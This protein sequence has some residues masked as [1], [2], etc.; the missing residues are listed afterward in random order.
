VTVDPVLPNHES[1]ETHAHLKRNSGFLR[2][3]EDAPVPFR[4][5][6]QFVEDGADLLRLADEMRS[7]R[8]AAAGVG[9]IAV[10]EWPPAIRA[11][12]D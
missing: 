3:N 6:Q 4:E 7:E 10:C 8:V 12:P 5:S 1:R 11:T 9:L 2:K